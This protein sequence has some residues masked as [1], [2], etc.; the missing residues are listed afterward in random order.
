MWIHHLVSQP[1]SSITSLPLVSTEGDTTAQHFKAVLLF[2]GEKAKRV[3]KRTKGT[4]IGWWYEEWI[5]DSFLP[6]ETKR[7]THSSLQLIHAVTAK[8]STQ[9]AWR[10][11]V[12]TLYFHTLFM[13]EQWCYHGSEQVAGTAVTISDQWFSNCAS[14]ARK[15]SIT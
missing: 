1:S 8:F 7:Q 10:I 13:D 2:W 14:W 11:K 9:L 12:D 15:T 4:E 3:R 5:Q 6:G